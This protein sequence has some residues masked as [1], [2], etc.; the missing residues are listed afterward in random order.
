[1]AILDLQL[2]W[3][4]VWVLQMGR[5]YTVMMLQGETPNLLPATIYFASENS[6]STLT[7]P[8]DFPDIL[9]T[10]GPKTLHVLKKDVPVKGLARRRC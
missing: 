5:T 3:N 4:W 10:D 9:P 7:T 1:M 8:Y 6:V 2:P